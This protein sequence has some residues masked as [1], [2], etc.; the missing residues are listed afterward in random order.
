MT[1][2]VTLSL[3][4]GMSRN[5]PFV[6]A[7]G[8]CTLITTT[9]LTDSPPGPN[10]ALGF[11]VIIIADGVYPVQSLALAVHHPSCSDG[12]ISNAR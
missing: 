4:L 6:R 1:T 11:L 2:N 3:F 5:V 12:R 10:V 9:R 8:E 7:H